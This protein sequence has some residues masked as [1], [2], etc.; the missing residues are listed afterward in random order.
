MRIWIA[1]LLFHSVAWGQAT[2]PIKQATAAELVERL[3]PPTSNG[4]TRSIGQRN[5]VV[6]PKSVDLVVQF[7]LDSAKLK[8]SNRPLLDSL[9]EAMKNERL[10]HVKFK[11][12][13]HTDAQGSEAYN[14]QLSQS[15][16]E[17]VL[18]Y[19][20]AKGVDQLKLSTEGKG[21]S[22]LLF[23]D[24]PFAAENRRVRITTIP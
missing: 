14:L 11:L 7:D 12:E 4:N 8:E 9:V 16:A 13:G 17:S 2:Q 21:F 15:R 22:E 18:A 6:Q 3:A 23:P 19:L 1:I 10:V 24:K 20:S 5:I